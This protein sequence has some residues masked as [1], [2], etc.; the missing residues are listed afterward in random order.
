MTIAVIGGLINQH[1]YKK[2]NI[3]D[4]I[5]I[6]ETA[7]KRFVEHIAILAAADCIKNDANSQDISEDQAI[8]LNDNNIELYVVTP[9]GNRFSTV[10]EQGEWNWL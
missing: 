1:V 2:E 8:L 9:T 4:Q 10:I 6:T 3:R 7:L 5:S